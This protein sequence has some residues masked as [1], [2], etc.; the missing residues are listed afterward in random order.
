MATIDKELVIGKIGVLNKD[1]LN[2]VNQKLI[3]VFQ[4]L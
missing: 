2:V 4:L 3:A 1:E